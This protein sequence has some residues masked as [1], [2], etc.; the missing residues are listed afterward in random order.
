M[1]LAEVLMVL[2]V[3]QGC[4][5]A[6]TFFCRCDMSAACIVLPA[7]AAVLL[8]VSAAAVIVMALGNTVDIVYFLFFI[9]VVAI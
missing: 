1:N 7:S 3:W 9:A 8:P 2:V 5:V 6:A 4:F